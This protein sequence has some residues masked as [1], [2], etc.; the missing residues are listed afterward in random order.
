MLLILSTLQISGLPL[1]PWGLDGPQLPGA[2]IFRETICSRIGRLRNAECAN[3]PTPS[4]P[5][6]PESHF[7]HRLRSHN[8]VGVSSETAYKL[9]LSEDNSCINTGNSGWSLE[10]GVSFAS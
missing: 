8:K 3:R 6:T 5:Q 2:A 1:D 7:L 10:F 9:G 4:Y